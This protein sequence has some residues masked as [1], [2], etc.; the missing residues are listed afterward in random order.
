MLPPQEALK[1]EARELIRNHWEFEDRLR[2]NEA[3]RAYMVPLVVEVG[4][5][6][7][8]HARKMGEDTG[9]DCAFQSDHLGELMTWQ[10]CEFLTQSDYEGD[11]RLGNATL[12]QMNER[13]ASDYF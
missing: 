12:Y 11:M 6:I 2:E 13:N 5:L 9:Q 3:L 1:K 7:R 8:R 4:D 10:L